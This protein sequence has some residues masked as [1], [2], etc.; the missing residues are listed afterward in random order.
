[1]KLSL[2]VVFAASS[3]CA[4]GDGAAQGGDRPEP[5]VP[6][7]SAKGEP[8]IG[9]LLELARRA[10]APLGIVA[11]D[12]R[13][14][15]SLIDYSGSDVPLSVALQSVVAQVPGYGLRRSQDPALAVIAPLSP[16]PVTTRFLSLVDDRFGPITAKLPDL[17]LGLCFH[18]HFILHPNE[19][20]FGDVMSSPDDPVF[21]VEAKNA[22]VEQI[23]GRIAIAS[24]GRWVLK[25]LPAAL[26]G[27]GGDVPL[28]MFS[29]TGRLVS[30]SADLCTSVP[31]R[32]S[33]K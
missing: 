14:C 21:R 28:A 24:G 12:D 8:A 25:P 11:D 9:A 20:I 17:V 7:F 32:A 23:L 1:M 5:R 33:G 27:V 4:A 6:Q 2:V 29:R 10:D 18:I 26:E 16:R 19:G 22:T 30:G 31:E 3:L 15:K 13:L